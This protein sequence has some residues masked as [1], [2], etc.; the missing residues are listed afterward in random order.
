MDELPAL[1]LMLIVPRY[2]PDNNCPERTETVSVCGVLMLPLGEIDSQVTPPLDPEA[3]TENLTDL[4]EVIEIICCWIVVLPAVV[5]N[6][7]DVGE[8]DKRVPLCSA[9]AK[10]IP[11]GIMARSRTAPA[12][13]LRITKLLL[14]LFRGG[15]STLSSVARE[16]DS[17]SSG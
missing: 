11:I 10:G 15:N 4:N 9:H 13:R 3:L 2:V 17:C 8:N 7:S 14:L 12:D 16:G 1:L 5:S 6:D